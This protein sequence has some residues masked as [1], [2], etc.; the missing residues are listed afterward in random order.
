MHRIVFGTTL[1]VEFAGRFATG[2]AAQDLTQY[3]DFR[4]GTT[5][6]TVAAS[7]RAP[8]SAFRTLPEEPAF[9]R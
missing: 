9:Q 7:T 2:L 5:V 1:G 4:L 6:A 8:V 3:R